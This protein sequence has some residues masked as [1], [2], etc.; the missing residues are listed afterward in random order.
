MCPAA[1]NRPRAPNCRRFA[2]V[3]I[4]FPSRA[5]LAPP[6]AGQVFCSGFVMGDP[7]A[8]FASEPDAN[9]QAP[10]RVGDFITFAGTLLRGDGKGPGGSDTI[11][12]HTIVAS[13]GIYTEPGTLPSY[14]AI[15]EFS[16]GPEFTT[17][18]NGVP[19]EAQS[20]SCSTAS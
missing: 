17:T 2:E 1:R 4:L 6:A 19:Q 11:S 5:D 3:P 13:V 18:F 20:A 10:L 9:Q 8:P 7:P 14:M 16:V 12:A 15:D